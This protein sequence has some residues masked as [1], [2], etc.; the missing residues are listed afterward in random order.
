MSDQD[1]KLAR[2]G[3]SA[4]VAALSAADPSGGILRAV[5]G[6]VAVNY[7]SDSAWRAQALDLWFEIISENDSQRREQ[8]Q[9]TGEE[10]HRH[11]LIW[12]WLQEELEK[13]IGRVETLE[14]IALQLIAQSGDLLRVHPDPEMR[15]Y[16]A[17]AFHN[18]LY[19]RERFRPVWVRR[20]TKHLRDLSAEHIRVLITRANTAGRYVDGQDSGWMSVKPNSSPEDLLFD[21]DLRDA[22][23]VDR[24]RLFLEGGY[25]ADFVRPAVQWLSPKASGST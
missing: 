21:A 7:A 24:S 1:D 10:F 22:R 12:G 23:L 2:L 16:L 8:Y 3:Q 9:E 11:R 4:A 20:L 18:A 17:Q 5:A 15:P 6:H 19:E 13:V 25:L 14:G